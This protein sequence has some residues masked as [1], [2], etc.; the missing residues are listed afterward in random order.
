MYELSLS[1]SAT[2]DITDSLFLWVSFFF[3]WWVKKFKIDSKHLF[4]IS[5]LDSR[6]TYAGYHEYNTFF[7]ISVFITI[8][9]IVVTISIVTNC[10]YSTTVSFY[11]DCVHHLIAVCCG[12]VGGKCH[13]IIYT[14][15]I[16]LNKLKKPNKLNMLVPGSFELA[17]SLNKSILYINFLL[18]TVSY[19]LYRRTRSL[20]KIG[21]LILSHK[22]YGSLKSVN[23]K[24]QSIYNESKRQSHLHIILIHLNIPPNLSLPSLFLISLRMLLLRLLPLC[25]IHFFFFCQ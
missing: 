13:T 5:S 18:S 12:L 1:S 4:L 8:L 25:F 7:F 16:Q 9:I 22:H 6:Q 3:L 19:R 14:L 11:W 15:S 2:S 10:S 23:C 20:S 24:F 17:C 21:R